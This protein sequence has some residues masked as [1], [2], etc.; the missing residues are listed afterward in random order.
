M[1]DTSQIDLG[2][3]D[4]APFFERFDRRNRLVFVAAISV[5]LV[6]SA[7]ILA[8]GPPTPGW[9]PAKAAATAWWFAILFT[10]V[11]LVGWYVFGEFIALGRRR[12]RPP[13]GPLLTG[14]DDA[15]NGVRI[16]NAGFAF[17]LVLMATTVIGQA[18]WMPFVFGYRVSA[19]EWIARAI[20]LA[21]G[22]ATIYLGNLWPRTPVPR[23]PERTA[24]IRMKVNRISGWMMV[25]T[26]LL[27]VLLGL[28]LPF[29]RHLF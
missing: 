20:M 17:N 9:M 18:L 7:V 24:A 13:A 8:H 29:L 25:I 11:F 21:V 1:T 22:A 12:G 10:P 5:S 23:A 27:A 19:G 6:M 28:F 16:A 2:L 3:T 4:L 14:T 26:G 15:R